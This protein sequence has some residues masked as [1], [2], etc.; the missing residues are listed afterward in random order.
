MDD[1]IRG[2]V[3]IVASSVIEAEV[4]PGDL[5]ATKTFH[6]QLKACRYFESFGESMAVRALARQLQDRLQASGRSGQYADLLH[7]ATAIA[8]RADA[9]WTTDKKVINWGSSGA[10]EEVTICLPYLEQGR[11]DI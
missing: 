5:R 2:R 4:R 7:V 1:M 9:F 6:Q 3:N 8:A 10:I 11:L